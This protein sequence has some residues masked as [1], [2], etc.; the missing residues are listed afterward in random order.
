MIVHGSSIALQGLCPAKRSAESSVCL[1]AENIS[2]EKDLANP[3]LERG[4]EYRRL[5]RLSAPRI[6]DLS[7]SM[8]QMNGLQ[9]RSRPKGP[10]KMPRCARLL[11]V[12]QVSGNLYEL[13]ICIRSRIAPENPLSTCLTLS[14]TYCTC[15]ISRCSS[16]PSLP[17]A[18]PSSKV[19]PLLP[20][21]MSAML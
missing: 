2:T 3:A 17:W 13:I 7:L 21:S 18:S 1:S 15:D 10:Y 9:P 14:H 6:V 5:K 12:H 4:G 8:C 11:H 20:P 19:R 16:V